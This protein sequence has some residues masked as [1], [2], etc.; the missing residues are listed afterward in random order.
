[1]AAVHSMAKAF[2]M[3]FLNFLMIL[4]TLMTTGEAGVPFQALE[5]RRRHVYR[6]L[7]FFFLRGC[8]LKMNRRPHE[9]EAD[10]S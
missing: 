6:Q 1:M 7:R 9:F 2:M 10:R 5:S 3:S 4:S 8:F